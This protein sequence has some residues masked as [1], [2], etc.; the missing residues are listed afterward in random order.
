MSTKERK[1]FGKRMQVLG[2]QD[3]EISVIWKAI[4]TSKNKPLAKKDYKNAIEFLKLK[5]NS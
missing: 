5:S 2:F 4:D 1:A 3:K